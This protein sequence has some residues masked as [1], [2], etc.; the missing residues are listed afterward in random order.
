MTP[1]LKAI[2]QE[3][4]VNS[5]E[6]GNLATGAVALE[7]QRVLAKSLSL[8]SSHRDATAHAELL[9]VKEVCDL[10]QSHFT[11][12]L[13]MLCVLEPCL[14]CLSACAQAGYSD[15]QFIISADRFRDTCNYVSDVSAFDKALVVQ[16]FVHPITFTHL[17][18]FE[19]EF[20]AVF[21]RAMQG[22]A[23]LRPPWK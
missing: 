7:G 23:H 13:V 20:S 1:N 4:M 8:V 18:E 6:L 16:H 2:L 9:L 5:A 10:K 22:S 21:A 3:L 17:R 15:V 12:G 19:D 14:M 11:P